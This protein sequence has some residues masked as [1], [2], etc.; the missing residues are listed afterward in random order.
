[1]KWFKVKKAF[2]KYEIWLMDFES[3]SSRIPIVCHFE[4]MERHYYVFQGLWQ[5]WSVHGNEHHQSTCSTHSTSKARSENWVIMTKTWS[6][7]QLPSGLETQWNLHREKKNQECN[8]LIAAS[9]MAT[10]KHQ[11]FK[12]K[13]LLWNWG[14]IKKKNYSQCKTAF[15]LC[16]KILL[17]RSWVPECDLYQKILCKVCQGEGS[18]S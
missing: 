3:Q 16:Y 8:N 13:I 5:A 11:V 18:K 15:R 10:G 1:M 4:I 2:Q 7:S 12:Q 14:I 17:G 6:Y 9:C